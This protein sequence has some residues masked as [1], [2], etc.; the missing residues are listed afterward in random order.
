MCPVC[1]TNI[2][3]LAVG[4]TSSE[5]LT[6]FAVGKLYRRKQTKQIRGG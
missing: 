2:A 4:A 6:A 5:G 1:V 3:L